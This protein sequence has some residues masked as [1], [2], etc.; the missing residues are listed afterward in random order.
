MPEMTE[1]SCDFL[2]EKDIENSEKYLIF[3]VLDKLYGF[4]SRIIGEIA[5]FDAVYPLPLT[6]S[7]ILGVVNRYSIPYALFDIGLLFYNTPSPHKKILI[8]KENIDRIAFLIDDIT[9]IEDV[10]RETMLNIERDAENGGSAE[11]VCASFSWNGNNVFVLDIQK[12]IDRA[13]EEMAQ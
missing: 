7:Y 4:P 11:A 13:A 10:Q 1:N 12:I 8:L 2:E 6:P 9:G 5:I 3:S